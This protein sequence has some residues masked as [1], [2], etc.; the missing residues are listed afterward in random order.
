MEDYDEGDLRD[1]VERRFIRV[2]HRGG[3]DQQ[4]ELRPTA[5]A[6]Y[7]AAH[8]DAAKPLEAQE[9]L[10][11]EHVRSH[12]FSARYSEPFTKW[13][14]AEALL[15]QDESV[16]NL[17]AIGHLC[18]EAMQLFATRLIDL[19][20]VKG[21]KPDR[22]RRLPS[23]LGDRRP[24]PVG[25]F[26]ARPSLLDALVGFWRAVNDIVQRQEHG[27][28]KSGGELTWEDGRR[29]ALYTALVMGECDRI[30]S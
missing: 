22:A 1:V 29:V 3:S 21:A 2:T 9:Q 26:S 7:D 30:L 10:A 23:A 13:R 27:G 15:W 19:H 20:G 12:V 17:T 8:R 14:D 28:Q 25:E 5:F 11:V 16:K 4:F 6:T 18:R 24:A